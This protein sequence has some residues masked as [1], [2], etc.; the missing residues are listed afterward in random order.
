MARLTHQ[1]VLH[2]LH[3]IPTTSGGHSPTRRLTSSLPGWG[4]TRSIPCSTSKFVH[5]LSAGSSL[6]NRTVRTPVLKENRSFA[7]LACSGILDQQGAG[8]RG[9]QLLDDGRLDPGVADHSQRVARR[10]AAK[11][12]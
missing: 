9:L 7:G 4:A 8:R 1:H 6:R 5:A 11:L 3:H 10:A 2:S 12:W